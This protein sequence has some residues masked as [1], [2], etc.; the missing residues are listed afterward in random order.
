MM[1]YQKPTATLVYDL[2]NRDN[3]QLPVKL[4]PENCLLGTP[5]VITGTRNTRVSISPKSGGPYLGATNVTYNRLVWTNLVRGNVPVI[6]QYA[7][8]EDIIGGNI[9]IAVACQWINERCGTALTP[10]DTDRPVG[11]VTALA[12]ERFIWNWPATNLVW[13]PGGLNWTRV[14]PKRPVSDVVPEITVNLAQL[15]SGINAQSA[16]NNLADFLTFGSDFSQFGDLL[17]T[18]TTLTVLPSTRRMDELV[19]YMATVTGLPLSN[20]KAAAQRNGLQ[21]C[22]IIKY[23]LPNVNVPEANSTDYN[24]VAIITVPAAGGWFAG[25]FLLHYKV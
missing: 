5:Q 2:I 4:T 12:G 25:R 22:R 6:D 16:P 9:K 13:A 24:N 23:A 14:T 3:P 7:R 11:S 17:A 10:T 20:L 21:G 1:D 19:Q 18:F 8:A 15:V